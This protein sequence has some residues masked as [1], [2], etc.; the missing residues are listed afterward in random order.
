MKWQPERLRVWHEML[1]DYML[2]HPGATR[3]EM[4]EV[5]QVSAQM[6]TNVSTSDL[7]RYQLE[8]RRKAR[9]EAVDQT[10]FEKLRDGVGQLAQVTVERLTVAAVS[11]EMDLD[12]VRETADMALRA[13]GYSQ[14][15]G[16][17]RPQVEVKNVVIVDRDLLAEARAAMRGGT[18]ARDND[19]RVALP[20]PAA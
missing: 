11:G 17:M 1:M 5:F 3:E 20:A 13:I 2:L 15:G 14:S 6:I 18:P 19:T 8:Q 12:G 10:V 4:A 9:A 16:A 7:F